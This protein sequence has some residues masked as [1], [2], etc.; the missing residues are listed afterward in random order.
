MPVALG[1]IAVLYGMRTIRRNRDWRDDETLYQSDPRRTARCAVHSHNL[2][3]VDLE[4]GDTVGAEREWLRSLGPLHPYASTLNNLGLLRA[5]Q[6]RY[7]EAISYFQQAMHDQPKYADPYKNLAVTYAKMGRVEDADREFREAVDLAPSTAVCATLMAIS[8]S[9]NRGRTKREVQ[10]TASAANDPNA[11]A[12]SNL[13]D[14]LL[15][16]NADRKSTRCLSVGDRAQCL[17]QPSVSWTRFIDEKAGRSAQALQ[18]YRASLDTDPYNADALAAVHR[19]S[20]P[21]AK[22]SNASVAAPSDP[23]SSH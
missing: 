22:T 1:L 21:L 13:G 7:D 5:S 15:R 8:C 6:K 9:T 18:E 14:L 12:L 23:P 10:F 17:R 19:L 2:G 4:R 11:D 3:V 16:R 20:A